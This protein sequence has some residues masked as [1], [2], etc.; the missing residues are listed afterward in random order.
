GKFPFSS[1]SLTPGTAVWRQHVIAIDY[2]GDNLSDL[3]TTEANLDQLKLL[4]NSSGS[5]SDNGTISVGDIPVHLESI[6]FDNDTDSDLIVVNRGDNSISLLRNDSGSFS[7]NAT[8][9]V[10][11]TPLKTVSGDWDNDSH[12]DLAVLASADNTIEIWL[13][14][15]SG[16]FSKASTQP[17]S[18]GSSPRDLISGDWNCDGYLDLATADYLGNSISLFYGQSSGADF[19]SPQTISI[20]KGPASLASADFN[21]DGRMDFVIAHRFYYT[22]SSLSLLTGDIGILL[23]ESVSNGQVVFTSETRLAATTESQGTPPADIL[24][25]DLDQDSKLDLLLS[26]PINQK[27]A[28]LSGKNYTGSLNCP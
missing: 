25:Q 24:I 20:G 27:L 8:L 1:T 3:V 22:T 16:N 9:S 18:S 5:F 12:T 23:S 15:G 13:N 17:S 11:N 19:S 4:L 21:N 10:G 2:N 26:L 28:V 6:D 7:E 14:D